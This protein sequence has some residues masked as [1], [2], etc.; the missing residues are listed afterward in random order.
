MYPHRFASSAV[1]L[2]DM[3]EDDGMTVFPLL[4]L[5]DDDSTAVTEQ[6]TPPITEA[7][8]VERRVLE[9]LCFVTIEFLSERFGVTR[10]PNH[11]CAWCE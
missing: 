9:F 2:H 6:V 11:C 4:V 10:R 5:H 1:Y 7:L 3:P 8:G